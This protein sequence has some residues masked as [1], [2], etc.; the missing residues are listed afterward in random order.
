MRT[1]FS[2]P[3]FWL[4]VLGWAATAKLII[5]MVDLKPSYQRVMII[6]TWV[7]W[8]VPAFDV[9]VYQGFINSDNAF[10]YGSV[11]TV[12]PVLLVSFSHQRS[13]L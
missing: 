8:M 3:S 6:F 10:V 4:G 9:L 7:L 12:L 5:D 13:Q 2:S 1:L 11:F